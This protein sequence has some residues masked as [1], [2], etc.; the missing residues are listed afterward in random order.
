ML[1]TLHSAL[2]YPFGLPGYWVLGTGYW[3][4]GTILNALRPPPSAL[5]TVSYA[6]ILFFHS[7]LPLSVLYGYK[8]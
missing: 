2:I 4:L 3:V 6:P 1:L 7:P 8:V 5:R